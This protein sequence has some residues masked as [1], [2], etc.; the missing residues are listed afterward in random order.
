MMESPSAQQRE[1]DSGIHETK[2]ELIKTVITLLDNV[3]LDE[4][5]SEKVLEISGISRGSLYHHFEDFSE[6]LEMAQIRRYSSYVDKTIEAMTKLFNSAN[7]RDE[8]IA[9]FKEVSAS[10]HATEPAH[11]RIER[12]TTISRVRDNPRMAAALGK[13]QERLTETLADLFH[14]LQLRKWGNPALEPRT[15]AV[16]FQAYSLGRAVDDFTTSQV[17]QEN[18]LLAVSLMIEKIFYPEN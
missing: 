6:L 3:A 5:T 9:G 1:V 13:E 14:K 4:I 16:F 8:L 15:A 11:S 18:W 10:V 17:S 12:V 2:N 7:S